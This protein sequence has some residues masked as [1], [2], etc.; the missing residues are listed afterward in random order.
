[1]QI[2]VSSAD[3]HTVY[4]LLQSALSQDEAVRK[5]AELMLASCENRPGFCSCLV[6]IIATKNLEGQSTARWLASVYFK[7]SINRYWRHRRDILGINDGEKAYLRNKLLELIR[8]ENNQVAVQLAILISKIAR[9]DY[10]KEWSDL[11]PSMVQKLQSSDVL[12]TQRAYMVLN[13]VLKELS[14]K[15]LAV[16]QRNF[17]EI[18]SQLFDYTWQH[19]CSDTQ[20]LLS[21]CSILLTSPQSGLLP[22]ENGQALQLTC[23]RWILCLKTLSRMLKFGYPSDSK[24]VQE[25]EPVKRVSPQFLVAI[26][27]LLRYRSAIQQVHA[28]KGFFEKACL[29]LMKTLVEVQKIHPYSFSDRSV[30]PPVLDFCYKV[31]TEPQGYDDSFEQFLIQCMIFV[32]TVVQCKEYRPAEMGCVVGQAT[33]TMEERKKNLAKQA[34]E[35]V[36]TLLDKEHLLVLCDILVRRYFMLT[37]CDLDNWAHHPETFHHEQDIVQWKDK[38]RPCAESLYL[39][40]FEHYREILAPLVVQILK[41][42][43]DNCPPATA[44]VDI[45]ISHRLL[46]KEAAY[47]AVGVAHYDLYGYIS[48]QSWYGVLAL[49]VQNRHPNGRILRRRVA[50]LLG[51]W[52]SKITRE[53]RRPVYFV[54]LE[55]LGDGDMAVQLAACHSLQNLIDDVHF[56]EDEFVEVVPTCLELLFRFM[57]NA[58]EFDSKLQVFN[59]VSLIIDRL[60]ERVAPCT[61][62]LISFIPQVWQES[63]GQSLLQIQVIVALQHLIVALGPRSSMCYDLLFPILDYSID[64]SKP[65]EVNMLEDG[66]QLW[67]AALRHAP[68]MVPQLLSLF[69]H[70]VSAVERNLDHL[71]VAMQIVES[72]VLLGGREFLRHHAAGVVRILDAVI[73]N[74]NEKGMMCTLPVIDILIQCF[75]GDGPPL[76]EGILQGP[77]QNVLGKKHFQDVLRVQMTR[78]H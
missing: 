59:L 26:Q 49:E 62:S 53:M 24:S 32:Q 15:R 74:T 1:M 20:R 14:T 21:S 25:V 48:F 60:G 17:V 45:E 78:K 36:T 3:V 42:A 64:A 16:D 30:I 46:L 39:T 66:M 58:E 57:Q 73:G 18:T 4:N 43:S 50:W 38:L 41:E 19:W 65:D 27:S 55:L 47:N 54:L 37:S 12:T 76:L 33:I 29:K 13:Q 71:Q 9:I 2:A 75:P 61:E 31:I 56:Y 11:F 22:S 6:E 40:L 10:P 44:N 70:L 67:Q 5:P 51:Q 23:E 68:T 77:S 7:N 69:P 72:Y 35:I 28:F 34:M 52:V 8:E 63:E